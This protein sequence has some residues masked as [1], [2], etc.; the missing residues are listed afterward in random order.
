MKK[1]AF[2]LS[3]S[4]FLFACGSGENNSENFNSKGF[5]LGKLKVDKQNSVNFNFTLNDIETDS[6]TISIFNGEEELREKITKKDDSL[7]FSFPVFD[8]WFKGKKDENNTITGKMYRPSL[9]KEMDF[10]AEQNGSLKDRGY[11]GHSNNT[12]FNGKWRVKF[13]DGGDYADALG[14]FDINTNNAIG[15]FLT[16][17]GDYRYLQG[18]TKGDSLFLS[19][20]D[21]S[22]VFL[23]KAKYH[24]GDSISGNFYSGNTYLDTWQG[25]KDNDF[26]LRS[27]TELTKYVG[28]STKMTFD[29]PDL[30]SVDYHFPNP[31]T[32]LNNI[33]LIQLMGTWCP[34]CKD[35]VVYYQE[36]LEKY[37][38]LVVVGLCFEYPETFE[39]K[40]ERVKALKEEYNIEY[41]LLIA[42]GPNKQEASAAMPFLNH[43]ISYP[44][45]IIVDKKGKVRRV[46]TGFYGPGTGKYYEEYKAEMEGFLESL[47]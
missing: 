14:V 18:S 27:A 16:E 24:E 22:H 15:T 29:F 3:V 36:L 40:V 23:F 31:M 17:T 10:Y 26:E 46:H 41:P 8:T 21:G 33:T 39:G 11:S 38:D 32:H 30:D 47:R 2:Y 45:T 19:C 43:V 6:A 12:K 35:E 37:D 44:T 25:K 7:F 20:F 28:D 5:W 13:N 42:G 4:V 1:I 9:K 34:N